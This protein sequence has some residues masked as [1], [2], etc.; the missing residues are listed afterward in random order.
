MGIAALIKAARKSI[1]VEIESRLAARLSCRGVAPSK[2]PSDK[3]G[4]GGC[5][6]EPTA[7]LSLLLMCRRARI[8]AA[9]MPAPAA[10]IGAIGTKPL[11]IA[12]RSGTGSVITITAMGE[13]PQRACGSSTLHSDHPMPR[14][15]RA[16]RLLDATER[17]GTATS[18]G[19]AAP[20][21]RRSRDPVP[22]R[23]W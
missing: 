22:G 1:E 21:C 14:D 4:S 17:V 12:G 20:W 11:V 2:E 13:K 18:A 23:W 9:R 16:K 5:G 15:L 3:L 6:C 7:F 19:N 10:L 8:R